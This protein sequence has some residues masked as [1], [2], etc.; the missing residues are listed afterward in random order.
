MGAKIIQQ[1]LRME[2]LGKTPLHIVDLR[3]LSAK[4]RIDYKQN[5][6]NVIGQ[7]KHL[8]FLHEETKI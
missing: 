5:L 6:V 2:N 4:E 3:K 1:K 8:A 7:S